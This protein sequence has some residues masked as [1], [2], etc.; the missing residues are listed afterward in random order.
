MIKLQMS[1]SDIIRAIKNT[2]YSPIGYLAARSFKE[3]IDDIEITKDSIIIWNDS[4][5]DYISYKYCIDNIDM[6]SI[7]IDEWED[8]ASGH[9]TQFNLDPILFCVEKNF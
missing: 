9:T 7:F 8:F 5:N 6:I 4:I 1:E 3:N 2:R